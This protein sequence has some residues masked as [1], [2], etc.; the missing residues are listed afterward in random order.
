MEF[1]VPTRN[2]LKSEQEEREEAQPAVAVLAAPSQSFWTGVMT[3]FL[4]IFSCHNPLQTQKR[5]KKTPA[6]LYL[7]SKTLYLRSKLNMTSWPVC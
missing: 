4:Q 2:V 1:C 6:T 7:R 3:T 5:V